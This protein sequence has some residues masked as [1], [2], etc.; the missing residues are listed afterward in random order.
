[1]TIMF[2]R[3]WIFLLASLLLLAIPLLGWRLFRH[4][5]VEY[6]PVVMD[7]KQNLVAAP[8]LV[9]P[10]HL[11]R[12]ERVLDTDG[13]LHTRVSSTKLLI[14]PR[15]A[16]DTELIWNYTTKAN[17]QSWHDPTPAAPTRKPSGT[18]SK[19]IAA[20]IGEN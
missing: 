3:P 1:M 14:R 6:I 5:M 10:D 17:D 15:L 18:P 16:L 13:E 7:A 9:T 20:K 19:A 11:D 4:R 12:L 2:R 8:L